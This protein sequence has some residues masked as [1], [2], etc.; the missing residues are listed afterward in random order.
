MYLKSKRMTIYTGKSLV[1]SVGCDGCDSAC[2]SCTSCARDCVSS[3]NQGEINFM[4]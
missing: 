1:N 3:A 2:L 4:D